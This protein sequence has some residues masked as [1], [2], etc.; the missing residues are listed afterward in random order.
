[1]R[2]R[3]KRWNSAALAVVMAS[4]P[5]AAQ[6]TNEA[7]PPPAPTPA[8][9]PTPTPT[10]AGTSVGPPQLRDFNLN[11][12]V[13]QPAQPAT[14]TPTPTPAPPPRATAPVGTG[15]PRRT[16]APVIAAPVQSGAAAARDPAPG[17][18]ALDL[19]PTPADPL[20]EG[21][22]EPTPAPVA[23]ASPVRTPPRPMRRG[24]AGGRGLQHCSRSALG[25]GFLWWRRQHDG[26]ERYASDH[27]DVGALVATPDAAPAPV[28][29][30]RAAPTPPPPVPRSPAP[31]APPAPAPAPVPAP[32]PEGIVSSRLTPTPISDGIVSS[33]LKPALAFELVPL[34]AET[35]AAEGAALIFDLII[36]NQ[37]SAPARDVLVEAKL[38]NAGPQVDAEVGRF[39]M[40]P[41]GTGDRLPIIGPMERASLKIRVSASAPNLAPLVVDGRKLLVPMIAINAFYRW[42][43]GELSESSS[44]LVGRGG[45]EGGKMAP[46]RLDLGAR[47]WSQLGA[48]LHSNGLQ[49]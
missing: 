29:L 33:R 25:A 35:D 39:F 31:A 42:S 1:M 19:P 40:Q 7:V 46:F 6:V 10:P 16:P 48:R 21:A 49:R 5:L 11:G 15:Q 36:V 3:M 30:P 14:P 2:R 8:P 9:T 4:A 28:P 20:A 26:E 23:E 17:T 13:T 18:V 38:I 45:A 34:R 12:T 41:A 43:G 27:G 22:L 24:S 44:F 37:G 32:L 47:S